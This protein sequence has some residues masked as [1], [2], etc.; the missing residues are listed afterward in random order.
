MELQLDPGLNEA[1]ISYPAL[2][3]DLLRD[4]VL[5]PRPLDRH[6]DILESAFTAARGGR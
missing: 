3:L 1:K 4:V 2:L 6:L 5:L